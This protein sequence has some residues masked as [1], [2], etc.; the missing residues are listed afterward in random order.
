MLKERIY[1]IWF[2]KKLYLFFCVFIENKLIVS[3]LFLVTIEYIYM[4]FNTDEL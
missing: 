2:S 3:N 4:F 1:T